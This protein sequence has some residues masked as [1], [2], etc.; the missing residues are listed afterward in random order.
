[1][2]L[3]WASKAVGPMLAS[4]TCGITCNRQGKE[5]MKLAT[6]ILIGAWALEATGMAYALTVPVGEVSAWVLLPTVLLF[7][8]L[9]IHLAVVVL[10]PLEPYTATQSHHVIVDGV[11]YAPK[12]EASSPPATN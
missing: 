8:L 1:M 5:R 6:R 4:P 7:L 10:Q 12:A 9:L 11:E 2:T 3:P